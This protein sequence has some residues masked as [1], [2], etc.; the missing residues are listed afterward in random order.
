MQQ[1][2]A[3]EEAEPN[4]HVVDLEVA[5]GRPNQVRNQRSADVDRD[6][7]VK[8]RQPFKD[9]HLAAVRTKLEPAR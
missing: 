2:V 5:E 8:D 7:H 4:V 9:I 3:H 1:L 6:V